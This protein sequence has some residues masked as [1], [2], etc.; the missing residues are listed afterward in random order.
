MSFS[1]SGGIY[2][3]GEINPE[4]T[5]TGKDGL[6]K[7]DPLWR[8]A[9]FAFSLMGL[10]LTVGPA[11]LSFATVVKGVAGRLP[12][13]RGLFPGELGI[14]E[15]KILFEIRLPRLS[16]RCWSGWP[17]PPPAPYT[18]DFSATPWP[19]PTCWGPPPARL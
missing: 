8:P 7:G 10:A 19:T 5:A 13:L 18:R 15:E 1:K 9:A 14:I 11:G 17:W 16:F 2:P 3:G 4:G 12:G 6:V